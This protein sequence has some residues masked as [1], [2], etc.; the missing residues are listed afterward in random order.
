MPGAAGCAYYFAVIAIL[1]AFASGF[2]AT[3]T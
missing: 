1:L 3:G 2:A